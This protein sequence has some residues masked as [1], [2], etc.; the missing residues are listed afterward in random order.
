MGA[1][2]GH[3]LEAPPQQSFLAEEYEVPREAEMS[4]I[5]LRPERR[6]TRAWHSL[7]QEVEP[8]GQEAQVQSGLS[9][10]LGVPIS[11]SIPIVFNNTAQ[12]GKKKKEKGILRG[13]N[14]LEVD[15]GTGGKAVRVNRKNH[16]GG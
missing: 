1:D 14:N 9:C 15:G 6:S 2:V 5:Q 10:H 7:L 4:P 16:Q 12:N 11:T 8:L 3:G 13:V